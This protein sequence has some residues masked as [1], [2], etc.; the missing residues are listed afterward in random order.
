MKE[1]ASSMT[2]I[3]ILRSYFLLMKGDAI[4]CSVCT[5]GGKFTTSDGVFQSKEQL[6]N[7]YTK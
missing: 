2:L 7:Y 1:K 4:I 6:F 3:P 5:V